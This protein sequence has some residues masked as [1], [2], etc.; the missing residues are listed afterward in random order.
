LRE[1]VLPV[2]I[3]GSLLFASVGENPSLT[4][5]SGSPVEP[6]TRDIQPPVRLQ[7][8][9][10][11]NVVQ[12]HPKVISGGLPEGEE[13]F[14]EL[15]ELGVRTIIS[16]DGAIPDVDAA[17]KAG[18]TYVHLPHGYDGIPADRVKE[19][20]KAV[21]DLNGPIYIHCHHGKHRSPAATSV[22][23]V[24]AGLIPPSKAV[25]V[26]EVA[27]TDSHYLGLYQSARDA[28][29]L[30]S[31]VL[32]EL[33]F[34]FKAICEVPPMAEAM[35]QL[36][37]TYDNL[38]LLEES[39]WMTP[40]EHPDLDAVHVS[41]LLKEH[42]TEMLRLEEVKRQPA[43]FQQWLQQSRDAAD[44]MEH[45]LSKWRAAPDGEAAP[46]ALRAFATQIEMSC[47]SCHAEYRDVPG[48]V[49]Q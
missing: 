39:N 17:R 10:L 1:T 4:A 38:R 2:A 40:S 24:S 12:V 13:A 34:E 30:M 29:P 9:S 41:V 25:A 19:L 43:D 45:A 46:D 23:C 37:H 11:P 28:V 33:E 47:Q 27:G 14:G 36:S 16:V 20:A 7:T 18:L 32:D 5:A 26:L 49:S 8:R 42:F 44:K 15:V 21:R 48:T 3:I 31:Q 6:Q 22:A 35:V